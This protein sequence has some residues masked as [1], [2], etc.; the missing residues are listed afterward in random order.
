MGTIP[1]WVQKDGAKKPPIG[2][3]PPK[4]PKQRPDAPS[5]ADKYYTPEGG[6]L[7]GALKSLGVDSPQ[8]ANVVRSGLRANQMMGQ[9]FPGTRPSS[10]LQGAQIQTL[11]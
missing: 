3:V 2:I 8:V 1:G 6:G 5:E 7:R 4:P 10:T 9:M 11:Q